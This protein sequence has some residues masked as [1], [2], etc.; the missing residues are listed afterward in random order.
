MCLV[1]WQVGA[2]SLVET[3]GPGDGSD[4]W[5]RFYSMPLLLS[6]FFVFSFLFSYFLFF[7]YELLQE[8]QCGLGNYPRCESGGSVSNS[9]S[10]SPVS[11][12]ITT[13][14]TLNENRYR[15]LAR[16]RN[17]GF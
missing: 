10:S 9:S 13:I 6:F 3:G 4:V 11:S 16:S 12:T 15:Y 5:G 2:F 1:I 14:Y 17:F 8:S 7:Q